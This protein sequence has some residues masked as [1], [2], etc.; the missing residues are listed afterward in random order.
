MAMSLRIIEWEQFISPHFKKLPPSAM[1]IGIF[2]GIHRGH[3]ALISRVVIERK[4]P[5]V[6]TFRQNPKKLLEDHK[7]PGDIFSLDQKLEGFMNLGIE[8]VILIDFSENFSK[9]KG[10]EFI[11]LL[12]DKGNLRFLAIGS[13]F[14]CGYGLD[15]GAA[16][17]KSVNEAKGIPTEII[18]PVQDDDGL[19]SSSRIRMAIVRGNIPLAAELLGRNFEL[20][21]SPCNDDGKK[22][23]FDVS[24]RL[25]PPP[26]T[27]RVRL[28]KKMI[29]GQDEGIWEGDIVLKTG[30]ICIPLHRDYPSG[31]IKD[32]CIAEKMKIE[33]LSGPSGP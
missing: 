15:T 28:N 2:D 26:G 16:L 23:I 13:N 29:N 1:T 6:V 8:Q 30:Q 31:N 22:L 33:F 5:T 11:S 20:D 32:L 4:I 7:Y 9:M 3:R 17:I 21:V 24:G 27:Y 25:L 12:V 14:R 10:Q 18:P 19:I